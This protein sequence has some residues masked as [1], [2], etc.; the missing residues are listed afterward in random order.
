MLVRLAV[1][2]LVVAGVLLA[3]WAWRRPPRR[4]SLLDLPAL[5][6]SGPAIVQFSTR[7]C[8]PCKAATPQLRSAAERSNVAYHQVDVGERPD[9]ARTHGIRSVPTIAVTRRDG[10]VLGVWTGLP[11]N[12]EIAAAAVRARDAG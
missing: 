8:A 5:G 10:T 2:A 3:V 9:V 6:I 1:A 12:G 11:A 7:Y 4:L